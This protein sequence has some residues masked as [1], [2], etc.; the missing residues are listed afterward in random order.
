LKEK[1][2]FLRGIVFPDRRAILEVHPGRMSRDS[3][4]MRSF[5]NGCYVLIKVVIL[6]L[7]LGFLVQSGMLGE[8]MLDPTENIEL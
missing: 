6:G 1:M 2:Q 5:F 7:C 8:K 3:R 4:F